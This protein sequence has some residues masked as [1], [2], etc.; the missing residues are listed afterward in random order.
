MQRRELFTSLFAKKKRGLTYPPYFLKAEDFEKCKECESKSCMEA[1]EENII[2]IKEDAPSLDFSESG[3][4][5]CDECAKVCEMGVLK[6]EYK[7]LLP[8]FSID[9]LGCLAWHHTICSA[10]KDAC[11]ENAIEFL[12]LFKPQITS[13]CTGCGFCVG[14]CPSGAIKK[15][16]G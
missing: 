11:L 15:G 14:V 4:T 13:E 1:C 16:E 7:R 2:Q 9:P 3:C 10:C 5:F 12:G 6:V 8:K